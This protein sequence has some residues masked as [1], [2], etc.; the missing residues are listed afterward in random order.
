MGDASSSG[1]DRRLIGAWPGP[2]ASQSVRDAPFSLVS[3]VASC[4]RPVPRDTPTYPLHDIQPAAR[5]ERYLVTRRAAAD[6]ASLEFDEDDIKECVRELRPLDFHKTMPSRQVEGL[7]QDVY[8]CRYLGR[9]IYIKVQIGG[10]GRA[11]VISF[12]TDESA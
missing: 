3:P 8:R 11:V 1:T 10:D 9:P 2:A 5:Q 7:W 12:K 4:Y 6:A